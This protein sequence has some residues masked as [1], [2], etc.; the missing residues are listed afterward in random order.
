MGFLDKLG[1]G[2]SKDEREERGIRK[3]QKKTMEKFGPPE[4][5]QGA[6]EELGKIRSARAIEALLMRYTIRVDPGITD[7]DE[8]QRVLALVHEAGAAIAAEPVKAFILS[9]DEI[10]WPLK[11]L[12]DL[13]PQEE[14]VRFLVSVLRK[15]GSEYNRVPEKRVLLL[16][17]AASHVSP[18]LVPVLLPFLDDMEDEVQI[19]AAQ[20]LAAQQDER[21]R[22]PLL[23][24]FLSAHEG[25]NA[26]V[27]EALA[28]L[29]AETGFD[30]KG[31]TP[32]VEAA[33]PPAYKLDSKGRVV[34]KV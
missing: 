14:V 15:T 30:V 11:A 22:E 1:I 27:R 8:K 29:L 25:S 2:G 5:R 12:S 18:E 33:L 17:A 24:R 21:A 19:A 28:G 6:I 3:L 32:K 10:S 26:R 31:Y 34:R 20:A 16:H 4:N 9:R 13:L 23:K 7:D